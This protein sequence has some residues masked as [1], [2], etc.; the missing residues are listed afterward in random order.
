VLALT[1]TADGDRRRDLDAGF[2]GC[3]TK[4]IHIH[5]FTERVRDATAGAA[6]AA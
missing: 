2:D 4:P 5:R 6:P 3:I 1:A